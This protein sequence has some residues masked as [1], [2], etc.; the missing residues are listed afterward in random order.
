MAAPKVLFV[1]IARRA[2]AGASGPPVPQVRERTVPLPPSLAAK[3]ADYLADTHPVYNTPTAVLWPRRRHGN[4]V[5]KPVLD[6]SA[7]LDLNA[8]QSKIVR[9]RAGGYW[10]TGQ[11]LSLTTAPRRPPRKCSA[12]RFHAH[13]GGHVAHNGGHRCPQSLRAMPRPWSH[14]QLTSQSRGTK[15][16][17]ALG[18]GVV[19]LIRVSPCEHRV[20]G[21]GPA[22]DTQSAAA[23]GATARVDPRTTDAAASIGAREVC[24][25]RISRS[26][27][28]STS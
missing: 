22:A 16:V 11:Q 23:G 12:A 26:F 27:P 17:A 21:L 18:T 8:L 19:L 13:G 28:Q 14:S 3:P 15:G 2:V 20:R 4:Q 7:P 1:C 24:L 25:I 6:W 5:H 9:P 10:I